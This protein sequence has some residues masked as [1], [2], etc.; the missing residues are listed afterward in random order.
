MV[1]CHELNPLRQWQNRIEEDI[2]IGAQSPS[3]WQLPH[4]EQEHQWTSNS[5]S[6]LAQVT[7]R[8]P[9]GQQQQVP[10]Q[11]WQPPASAASAASAADTV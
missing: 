1:E 4:K 8:F 5:G 2:T 10:Q 11:Q 6:V 9:E 7:R 3:S